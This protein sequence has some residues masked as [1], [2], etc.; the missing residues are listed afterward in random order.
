MTI[1]LK[2]N[3]YP[4]M[5]QSVQYFLLSHISPTQ[6][7]WFESMPRIIVRV[8]NMI[9]SKSK[10]QTDIVWPWD[11]L[12]VIANANLIGNWRH[13]NCVG[14]TVDIIGIRGNNIFSPQNLTFKIMASITFFI[15][16]LTT[17][18]VPLYNRGGSNYET[19]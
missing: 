16:F 14:I 1:L 4:L 10:A 8:K 2:N 13:L 9:Y 12:I 15:N 18:R 11:L 5:Q 7:G 19:K 17:Y 6:T 3:I